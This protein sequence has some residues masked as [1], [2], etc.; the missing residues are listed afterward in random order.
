MNG[1]YFRNRKDSIMVKC[2]KDYKLIGSIILAFFLIH[3]AFDNKQVFWYFYTATMLFLISISIVFEKVEN[4]SNKYTNLLL[5]I[6]SGVLLYAIFYLGS[7]IV[8]LLS[9]SYV[10]QIA[11]LYKLFT[12]DATWHYLVLLFIII[13]G[14]EIFWRGFVLKRLLSFYKPVTAILTAAIINGLAYYFTGY[15]I[16]MIAGL[17]SGLLWGVLY[18]WKQSLPLVI[19]SHL[20]FDILLLILLP[21]S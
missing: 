9:S 11:N 10:K 17:V 12:I 8:P 4:Q 14:E 13:P 18:W 21:L 3:I 19:I 6:G 15:P 2:L 5:G 7:F 20:A 16:L 1:Q